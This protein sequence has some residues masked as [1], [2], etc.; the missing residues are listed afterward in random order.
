VGEALE[1]DEAEVAVEEAKFELVSF[2]LADELG[3]VI[4]ATWTILD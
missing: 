3:L 1:E 4:L 2:L